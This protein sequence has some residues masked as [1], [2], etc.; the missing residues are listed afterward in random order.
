MFQVLCLIMYPYIGLIHTY[1]FNQ[2][3]FIILQNDDVLLKTNRELV[4]IFTVLNGTNDV[5][6]EPLNGPKAKPNIDWRINA[7]NLYPGKDFG[8]RN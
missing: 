6:T 7:M 3:S 4:D 2:V 1:C 5:E 8:N